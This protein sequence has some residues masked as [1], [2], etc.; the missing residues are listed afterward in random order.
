MIGNVTVVVL[1]AVNLGLRID[2][3]D[4]PPRAGI[5]FSAAAFLLLGFTGWKWGELAYR[6]RV[7]ISH[8]PTE[9]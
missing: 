4:G 5:W 8:G 2:N 7:G 1:E 3:A 6:H 9:R